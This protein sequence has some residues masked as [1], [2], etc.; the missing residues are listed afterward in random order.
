MLT[1]ETI[2]REAHRNVLNAPVKPEWPENWALLKAGA[3][4]FGV[5]FRAGFDV[6]VDGAPMF[7]VVAKTWLADDMLGPDQRPFSGPGEESNRMGEVLLLPLPLRG[8]K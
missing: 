4:C 5:E 2:I 1:P 8:M 7:H 6:S 3:G